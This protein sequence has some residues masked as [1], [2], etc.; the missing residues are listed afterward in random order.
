MS[1]WGTSTFA[2]VDPFVADMSSKG[3]VP[4]V[5]SVGCYC[6]DGRKM[7]TISLSQRAK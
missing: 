4:S 5:T 6:D 2:S 7:F 1:S 3:G